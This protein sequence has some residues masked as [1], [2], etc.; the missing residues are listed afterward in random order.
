MVPEHERSNFETFQDCL[1]TSVIQKLAPSSGKKTKKRSIKGRKNEIKP[2]V[3]VDDENGLD[4]ATELADFVEYLAEQIF[5]SLP[6]VLRTL[7]YARIQED[8]SLKVT[9]QVPMES[10]LIEDLVEPLPLSISDSLC[11]YHLMADSTDLNRFL[12]AVFSSYITAVTS[13]PPEYTPALTATRPDGCEIC[14]REHLPLTYHHLIPRQV[15]AKVVKRG[16]H[17]EWELNKV[18]WLCRA[19]HS[20]V[21][22]IASNE[23]LARDLYSVDLLLDREDVQKWAAWIGRVRWKA[24]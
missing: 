5:T 9:Y 18:A 10:A 14:G 7:S 11:S 17:S 23:E 3:K 4:D 22:K 24:K 20:C 8:D 6:S 12:E 19:C 15:H 16:W 2:V 21:H 1:S 13:P